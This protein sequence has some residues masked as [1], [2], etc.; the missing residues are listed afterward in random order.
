MYVGIFRI[1][2]RGKSFDII[3]NKENVVIESSQAQTGNF[4]IIASEEN[5]LYW[6]FLSKTILINDSIRQITSE[7]N[8]LYKEDPKTN[9]DKLKKLYKQITELEL[10]K[11]KLIDSLI[12]VNPD[13]FATRIIKASLMPDFKAYM[14][15]KDAA[16]Y[17]N[18]AEFLREHF[19]DNVDF[20]D[21]NMLHTEIIYDK[22]GDYLW[23]VANPPSIDSY[24]KAIDFILI[25]ASKNN[26]IYDY[27]INTL[28]KSFYHSD[29]DDVYSYVVEKY[30]SQ[31]TCYNDEK[32]KALIEKSNIIKTLKPGNKVPEII[33]TDVN[34]KE[35]ILD[36]IKSPY[37]LVVFWASWC[38][39]CE[40]AMPEIKNIYSL[41]K[42]KGLEIFAYSLDSAKQNWI[43]AT[44]RFNISWINTSDLKGYKSFPV[45]GYNIWS[46]PTFFLLDKD[47]KIIAKPA[48]VYILK[49]VLKGIL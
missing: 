10:K 26:N 34:G 43:D 18:E 36:S 3:F 32:A 7:G 9:S 28:L 39:F 48:S 12:S 31:S 40:K 47:K 29:W 6:T 17:P 35:T 14:K 27:V 30:I 1:S 22:I 45:K 4:K 42:P 44:N 23:Y 21:S 2:L 15:K 13:L 16:D 25:R 20:A 33:S 19:F 41:Y 46:T 5:K 11:Q 38:E 37:T 24:K 8:K 49:E